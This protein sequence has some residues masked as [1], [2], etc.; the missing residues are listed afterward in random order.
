MICDDT[1]VVT[2]VRLITELLDVITGSVV[3]IVE[4]KD[5]LEEIDVGLVFESDA[6]VPETDIWLLG[7]RELGGLTWL[8]ELSKKELDSVAV[9]CRVELEP[10]FGTVG[11]VKSDA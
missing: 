10:E 3:K 6:T 7:E 5:W 1:D 11:V 4:V 9:D 2:D 8:A